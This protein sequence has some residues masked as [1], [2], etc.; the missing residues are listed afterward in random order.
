MRERASERGKDGKEEGSSLVSP[1]GAKAV[2][3]LPVDDGG[4]GGG[5]RDV[6]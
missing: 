5:M 6:R 2:A 4:P 3:L 1:R